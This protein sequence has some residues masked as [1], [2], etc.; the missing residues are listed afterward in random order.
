MSARPVPPVST[1]TR[2]YWDAVRQQQLV[3]QEC[4]ACQQ[5]LF[6]PKTHCPACGSGAL[7]WRPVSGTG[8]IYS[9]TI[10]RR[11]P[12][13]VFAEQ[14]PL[15][16]AIVELDEGPRMITNIVECA[17]DRIEVG[18]AVQ[19]AFEPIDDTDVM[20]PVFRPSAR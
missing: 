1:L 15:A 9:F 8:T 5:R 14:C 10:A 3:L 12:H 6:P 7:S 17:P 2:P 16:I 4:D 20:L 11:P 13:P 19:V 18:M